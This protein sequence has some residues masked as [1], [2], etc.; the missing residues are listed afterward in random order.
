M[1]RTRLPGTQSLQFGHLK[2]LLAL[3]VLASWK[4]MRRKGRL[5]DPGRLR[6]PV[7]LH[8]LAL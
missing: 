5:Q 6:N 4:A 3:T 1:G 2:A 8:W 7:M